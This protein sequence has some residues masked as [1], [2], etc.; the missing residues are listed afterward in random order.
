LPS[1]GAAGEEDGKGDTMSGK[2]LRERLQKA[3][4]EHDLDALSRLVYEQHDEAKQAREETAAL[5]QELHT[6]RMDGDKARQ[7]VTAL[8]TERDA[9][10]QRAAGAAGN[11]ARA[12]GALAALRERKDMVRLG[13]TMRFPSVAAGEALRARLDKIAANLRAHLVQF[14]ADIC[15]KVALKIRDMSRNQIVFLMHLGFSEQHLL[16]T[17]SGD[18]STAEFEVES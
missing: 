6:A 13:K 3:T 9:L 4:A 12:E 16:R 15:P 8:E 11:A 10:R 5:R 18:L 14:Y 7:R 1:A 2:E 17:L